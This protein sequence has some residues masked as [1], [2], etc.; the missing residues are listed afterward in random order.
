MLRRKQQ[1]T[2]SRFR[3]L[4]FSFFLGF[5]VLAYRGLGFRGLGFKAS[6]TETTQR[7]GRGSSGVIECSVNCMSLHVEL[8]KPLPLGF[9]V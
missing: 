2:R 8:S 9:R 6:G 3:V 7:M 1:E 5:S 4:G